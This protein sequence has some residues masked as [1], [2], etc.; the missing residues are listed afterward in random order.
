MYATGIMPHPLSQIEIVHRLKKVGFTQE[1]A[2]TQ[3]QIITEL[4]ENN[5]A[6]KQ[7]V[8]NL[9]VSADNKFE[10][11]TKDIGNLRK[12]LMQKIDSNFVL[13]KKEMELM[14]SEILI[15]ITVIMGGLLALF[16]ALE[17]FLWV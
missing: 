7:D 13:A 11:L 16:S 2:E 3:T 14:K 9:E 5:L 8:K 10:I 4:N 1:Q 6:T 17:K 12:D 15:K